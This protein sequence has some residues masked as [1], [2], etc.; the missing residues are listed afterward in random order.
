MCEVESAGLFPLRIDQASA[1]MYRRMAALT[2]EGS[3]RERLAGIASQ[4][5]GWQQLL[6][7]KANM[8]V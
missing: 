1:E 2:P 3:E 5:P 7:R 8:T 6:G 4:Q